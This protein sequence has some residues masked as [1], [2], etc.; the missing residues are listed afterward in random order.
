MHAFVILRDP[1]GLDH[2]LVHGDLVGRLDTAALH[3]DDGRVSEAH[4]MV[5]LRDGT[6]RLL[7]L[8]GAF[9]VDGR[10]V[11]ELELRPGQYIQLAPD[12]ALEVLQVALPA[13]VLGVQGPGLARRVLPAVCSILRGPRVLS[14]WHAEA[15]A[16]IWS[17]GGGWSIRKG[18]ETRPLLAGDRL[19]ELSF[20][21]VLLEH[22]GQ[23]PTRQGGV[24][25]ALRLVANYD[26]VHIYRDGRAVVALAG[27]LARIVSE[28]VALDGPVSWSVL[29]SQIWPDADNLTAR[30]RLDAN[31]TR[32]RRKL[33]ASSVRS[34]LV[35]T[36]GAGQIELLLYPHDSVEDRT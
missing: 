21:A 31:L 17:T 14:G 22:A 15:L 18:G 3:I 23:N 28:L 27:V 24:D 35:R 8:R 32:I 2:E 30:S 6:L 10:T 4:A 25:G 9:A 1:D 29:T 7:G 13:Q 34:D 19:G 26:T 33:R 20:V 12:V 16:Q 11:D 5:S 36:D